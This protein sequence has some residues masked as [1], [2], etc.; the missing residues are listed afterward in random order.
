M[1]APEDEEEDEPDGMGCAKGVD[2]EEEAERE[3]REE[4]MSFCWLENGFWLKDIA[5]SGSNNRGVE[6]TNKLTR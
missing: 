5:R 1:V 4:A 2:A 3:R 6:K